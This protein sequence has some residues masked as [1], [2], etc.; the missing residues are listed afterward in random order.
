MDKQQRQAFYEQIT[1]AQTARDYNQVLIWADE[2]LAE[3]EATALDEDAVEMQKQLRR[4]KGDAFRLLRQ[5]DEAAEAYDSYE[6]LLEPESEDFVD[7][8]WRRA[9]LYRNLHQLDDVR[10]VLHQAGQLAEKL[11]Y[12]RGLMQVARE[13]STLARFQGDVTTA[14]EYGQ[15]A[16]RYAEKIGKPGDLSAIW[17]VMS[18]AYHDEGRLD[19]AIH[20]YKEAL[21]FGRHTETSSVGVWLSNLGECYQ[22]L[23]AMEEARQY[24]QEALDHVLSVMERTGQPMRAMGDIYRNL[25]LDLFYLGDVEGGRGHLAQAFK[26]LEVAEDVDV[27]M[28]TLYTSAFIDFKRGAVDEGYETA[29]R[30]FDLATEM[31]ANWHLARAHYLLGLG[32]QARGEDDLAQ[33]SW[34]QAQFM[35][36]DTSQQYLLWRVH[37]VLGDT[38]MNPALAGVHYQIA[39]ETVR[40]IVAP[41]QDEGLRASFLGATEV[42]EV[43]DKA[44]G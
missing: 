14:I 26:A 27:L 1:V 30:L 8:L 12:D 33:A 43:L 25:G 32:Q 15:V 16:V 44:G 35:A 19:K 37:A 31:K 9:V 41:I 2:L 20:G 24:H 18:L 29:Q 10:R 42:K 36:H 39:A 11:G 5:Y 34:Q 28:Q 22:D 13:Q 4:I 38:A 40:Q 7:L 3:I 23:F 17:T 6:A 21:K